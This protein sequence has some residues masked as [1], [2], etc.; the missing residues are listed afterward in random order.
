MAP[1]RFQIVSVAQHSRGAM[2][3]AQNGVFV[4]PSG[5]SELDYAGL[6]ALV[7]EARHELSDLTPESV[8]ALIGLLP[9]PHLRVH[10]A[11][12]DQLAM[13]IPHF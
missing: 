13:A 11:L 4:P 5:K 2:E 9:G 8:D 7:A 6:Q 12:R 10:A 1:L 3:A